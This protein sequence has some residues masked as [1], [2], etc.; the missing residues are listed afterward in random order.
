MADKLN[1]GRGPKAFTR[2]EAAL[3]APAIGAW[4]DSLPKNVE[5]GV[6]LGRS[7]LE[8]VRKLLTATAGRATYASPFSVASSSRNS[9][10][11]RPLRARRASSFSSSSSAAVS[12]SARITP[13]PGPEIRAPVRR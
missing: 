10:G 3:L 5:G 2:G 4:L 8:V 11:L 7:D 6:M 12:S 9:R 13:R 1:G